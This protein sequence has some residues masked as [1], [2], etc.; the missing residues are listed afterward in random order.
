MAV[1]SCRYYR[2]RYISL[3]INYLKFVIPAKA[4]HVV[5]FSAIQRHYWMPDQARH[6][7][8]H[9]FSCRVNIKLILVYNRVF[10]FMPVNDTP[11][12]VQDMVESAID[13]YL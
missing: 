8:L 11:A 9:I 7:G 5:K 12:Q 10:A 4:G 1:I 13:E 2:D 3:A 6:D